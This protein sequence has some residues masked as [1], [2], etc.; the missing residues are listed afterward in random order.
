MGCKT[1]GRFVYDSATPQAVAAGGN[2]VFS[3]A[4][5]SNDCTA[6]AGG[7]V[8]RIQRPGLY[9]VFFNATIEATAAGAVAVQM[10]HNGA[11]VPGA[12]AAATLAAAGDLA[13]LAFATPVTVRCC[14]NDT[15]AFAVDVATSATVA[16]CVVEK[17]A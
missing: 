6:S 8:V 3:D 4:T 14:A 10:R 16:V 11:A 5:T 17:V 2:L 15:V 12:S 13:S 7:G 1:V 9:N